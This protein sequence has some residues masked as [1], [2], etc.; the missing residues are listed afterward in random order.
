MNVNQVG[1]RGLANANDHRMAMRS[2]NM[3]V[4]SETLLKVAK[5]PDPAETGGRVTHAVYIRNQHHTRFL[6]LEMYLVPV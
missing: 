5:S 3:V 4:A 1:V 6:P 2:P